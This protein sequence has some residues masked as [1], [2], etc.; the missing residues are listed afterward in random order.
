MEQVSRTEGEEV[1]K[2]INAYAYFECSTRTFV[3]VKE[4]FDAVI[5]SSF[6]S[7]PTSY[8]N[9]YNHYVIGKDTPNKLKLAQM[10]CGEETGDGNSEV[11]TDDG[12]Y[13]VIRNIPE[14][15]VY[16]ITQDERASKN[17]F[18]YVYDVGDRETFEKARETQHKIE[19]QFSYKA[20]KFILYGINNNIESEQNVSLEELMAAALK[21][22][23]YFFELQEFN[24]EKI[25]KQLT[26]FKRKFSN[27]QIY[28]TGLEGTGYKE[29]VSNYVKKLFDEY[30][31]CQN[32]FIPMK[33]Y[34]MN[35]L[36]EFL[37]HDTYYH[38][39]TI[40]FVYSPFCRETFN[41]IHKYV[42]EFSELKD[43]RQP[44]LYL[45]ENKLINTEGKEK[46][47]TTFETKRF[48]LMKRMKPLDSLEKI[49][50]QQRNEYDDELDHENQPAK[51]YIHIFCNEELE[52]RLLDNKI[53]KFVYE[54][55]FLFI[56]FEDEIV[57]YEVKFH[58]GSDYSFS[59][60]AKNI[61]CFVDNNDEST[62]DAIQESKSKIKNAEINF[63]VIVEN[64]MKLDE[65]EEKDL[66]EN[67]KNKYKTMANDFV[68]FTKPESDTDTY[69]GL[70]KYLLKRDENTKLSE[71][72]TCCRI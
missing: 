38:K 9:F 49:I 12:K 72:K 37:D 57:K 33:I 22:S 51:D 10:L 24:L 3:N 54:G 18:Y 52:E 61:F 11:K 19:S 60:Y 2:V 68:P 53:V 26:S 47:V 39:I 4:V 36:K 41:I 63:R 69:E 70:F 32:S 65:E 6:N 42:S 66:I 25:H 46:E 71:E 14:E 30:K 50:E 62:I 29:I 45:L 20:F 15:E 27:N 55:E 67:L 7:H 35:P 13:C 23:C 17:Y 1:A 8:I 59:E 28:C 31:I 21:N 40:C 34:E 5:K 58:H 56:R 64:A 43:C 44:P 48:Y 16:K